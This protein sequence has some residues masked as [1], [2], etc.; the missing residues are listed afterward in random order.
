MAEQIT[1]EKALELVDFEFVDGAWRVKRVAGGFIDMRNLMTEQ[2]MAE[3]ITLEEAL[4]LVEFQKD[5]LGKWYVRAVK[6]NCD[7]VEGNCDIVEGTVYQTINGRKWQY[8]ETPKEA[9]KRLVKEGAD[10]DKLLVV[11]EQLEDN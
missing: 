9:L 11:I 5:C 10:E 7:I 6:G 2:P 8:V 3:Q 1:L 4:E